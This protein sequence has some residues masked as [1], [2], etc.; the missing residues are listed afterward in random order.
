[1]IGIASDIVSVA[2]GS[3]TALQFAFKR[4][5]DR[6]SNPIPRNTSPVSKASRLEISTRWSKQSDSWCHTGT[7]TNGSFDTRPDI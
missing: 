3:T 1:M 6:L 5:D 2:D 7:H 4:I